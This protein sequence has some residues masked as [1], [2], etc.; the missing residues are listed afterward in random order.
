M[1]KLIIDSTC[2]IPKEKLE[3]FD[4]TIL[5]ITVDIEGVSYKDK[6]DLN[7]EDFYIKIREKNV[8]P[9]TAQ[10]N[11]SAFEEVFQNEIDKDNEVI[12]LTISSTLSGTFNS[13]MIAKNTI[14]SSKIHVIDS[15]TVSYGIGL[16]AIEAAKLIKKGASLNEVLDKINHII[17]NQDVIAYLDTMEM[18]KRGG[19]I[20]KS[21]ATIGNVLRIKPLL[22]M[23]DGEL[24][25]IE[26]AKGKKNALKLIS[27][28]ISK[29]PIDENIG[30]YIAHSNIT[31][32]ITSELEFLEKY[33]IK[34]NVEESVIG[35]SVGTH[36]GENAIAKFFVRK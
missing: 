26:K 32:G 3:E 28:Y 20:P 18:L 25:P 2:D 16:I 9:K 10:I 35:A 33:N 11:P 31:C 8:F 34:Y 14:D 4:I 12:C 23:I 24:K 1:I 29:K 17:E 22:S 7:A 27:E 15:K 36:V 5:P 21:I 19:R 30:L 6:A 13:A